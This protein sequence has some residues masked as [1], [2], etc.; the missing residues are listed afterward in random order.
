M[1]RGRPRSR[2]CY[3]SVP[4]AK[5]LEQNKRAMQ[6]LANLSGKPLVEPGKRDAWTETDKAAEAERNVRDDA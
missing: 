3:R 1:P 5:R 6:G 2:S 4:L